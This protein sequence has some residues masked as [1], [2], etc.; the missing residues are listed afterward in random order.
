M[1]GEEKRRNLPS[2]RQERKR[3]L[4]ACGAAAPLLC[5]MEN[6]TA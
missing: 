6:L 3:Q 2:A 4:P 1:E 5:V